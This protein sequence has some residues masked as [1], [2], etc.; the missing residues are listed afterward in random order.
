MWTRLRNKL[1]FLFRR[2]RFD[3]EL[4]EEMDFHREMLEVDKTREGLAQEAAVASARR[5]LGN[6]TLAR[7]FSKDAESLRLPRTLGLLSGFFGALALLLATMGLYGI[8]A[9]TVARRRNE[10]GVRI[11]LGATRTRVIRMVLGD[12]GRMVAAGVA[13]G[14]M[15]SLAATRFVS[16][17]LYGVEPNDPATLA[18]SALA[19]VAVAIGAA[20]IPA[21]RSARLDPMTALRED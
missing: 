6:T 2:D 11:A 1:R 4:A 9:Y 20:L 3:R 17:F 10:I 16:S 8:M 21:R 12:V 5:Q 7:E 18:L 14:V 19:L 13:L 15:L